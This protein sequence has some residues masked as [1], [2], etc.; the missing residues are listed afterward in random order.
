MEEQGL[1]D[2]EMV[3]LG[4]ASIAAPFTSKA[5]MREGLANDRACLWFM[6]CSP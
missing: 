3:K 6:G 4:D 2:I 1:A 5:C